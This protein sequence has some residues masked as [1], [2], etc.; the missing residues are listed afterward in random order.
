MQ[1]QAAVPAIRMQPLENAGHEAA[2]ERLFR[3]EYA[4]VVGVAFQTLRD[5][6]EAEDVAQEA[7]IRFHEQYPPDASFAA[8]WLCRTAANIGLTRLRSRRRR[9][10][11][12]LDHM[13][14]ARYQLVDPE[15]V[16]EAREQRRLVRAALR[17]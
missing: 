10:H 2:F 8:A 3:A 5:R 14:G 6:Q 15:E 9:E 12:E 1:Q 4:R 7:F 13:R 17:R 16:L 11:R